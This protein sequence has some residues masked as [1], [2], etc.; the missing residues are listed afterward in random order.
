[1][2][3]FGRIDIFRDFNGMGQQKIIDVQSDL[4]SHLRGQSGLAFSEFGIAGKYQ[5][6]LIGLQQ[7][8]M[9]DFLIFFRMRGRKYAHG[10]FELFFTKILFW[11]RKPNNEV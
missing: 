2:H 11:R 1:M 4:I 10:M 6:Q 8:E 5:E 3:L 9:N 7:G